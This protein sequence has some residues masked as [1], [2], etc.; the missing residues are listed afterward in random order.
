MAIPLNFYLKLLILKNCVPIHFFETQI[1]RLKLH[2]K[3]CKAR[4][5]PDTPL[6]ETNYS[7]V[8]KLNDSHER[9]SVHWAGKGTDVLICLARDR[10]QTTASSSS[11][12][13]SYDY[14]KHFM[15]NRLNT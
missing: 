4:K 1:L 14:G 2:Q 15:K 10:L 8:F 3:S 5:I 13:F 7:S 11:V 9:L 6:T 12:Y